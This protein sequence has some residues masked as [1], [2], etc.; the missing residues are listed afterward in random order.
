MKGA[1]WRVVN[2]F[3]NYACRLEYIKT[4]NGIS[5]MYLLYRLIKLAIT[6][7]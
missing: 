6:C 3:N 2:V 4:R 5:A 1:H 7:Y